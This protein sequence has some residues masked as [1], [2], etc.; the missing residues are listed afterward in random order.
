[1]VFNWE[2]SVRN[3]YEDLLADTKQLSKEAPLV[4]ETAYTLQCRVR[5]ED[6]EGAVCK[7]QSLAPQRSA[8]KRV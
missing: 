5:C 7:K 4:L 6:I 2:K 1:M 3:G 8:H